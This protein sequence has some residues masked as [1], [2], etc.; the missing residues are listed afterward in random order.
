MGAIAEV[1]SNPAV[2]RRRLSSKIP[3]LIREASGMRTNTHLLAQS[4]IQCT[5]YLKAYGRSRYFFLS[6][7]VNGIA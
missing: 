5:E 3:S 6:K 2:E 1:E 7:V 4:W